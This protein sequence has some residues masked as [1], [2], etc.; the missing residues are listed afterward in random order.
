ME[1]ITKLSKVEIQYASNAKFKKPKTIKT[2]KS[3]A[4][5]K[6][7]KK[8]KKYYFRIRTYRILNKKKSYSKWS[9]IKKILIKR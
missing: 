1:K 9:T 7:L 3:F 6:Q 8:N 4:V 5:I 2:K